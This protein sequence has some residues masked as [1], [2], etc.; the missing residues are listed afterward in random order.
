MGLYAQLLPP[1]DRMWYKSYAGRISDIPF[2]MTVWRVERA[3]PRFLI[4][5]SIEN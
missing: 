2:K 3:D 4:T 1:S 5:V